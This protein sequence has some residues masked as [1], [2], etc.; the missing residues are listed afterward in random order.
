M[1]FILKIDLKLSNVGIFLSLGGKLFQ[2]VAPLN[3]ILFLKVSL[4]GNGICST[5]PS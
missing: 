2:S 4:L 5:G 3:I 1:Q